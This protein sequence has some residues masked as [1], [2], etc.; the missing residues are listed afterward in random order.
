MLNGH[1]SYEHADSQICLAQREQIV[2]LDRITLSLIYD[3]Y[4]DSLQ[5]K[6]FSESQTNL[7]K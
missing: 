5:Y 1:R 2:M 4:I 6:I 3:Y 7:R